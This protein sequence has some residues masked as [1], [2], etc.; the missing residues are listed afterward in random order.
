MKKN[1]FASFHTR[2]LMAAVLAVLCTFTTS[3]DN[4]EEDAPAQ[5]KTVADIVVES[6]DFTILEAAMR[7]AGQLDAFK[8][9]NLTV[10]APNDAAFRA[11][12]VTDATSL[13]ALSKEQLT[14][15]LQYHVLKAAV[16]S[17]GFPMEKNKPVQTSLSIN[18]QAVVA[19][20]TNGSGGLFINGAKVITPDVQAANGVI[21]VID[22]I[23][24]P[25]PTGSGGSLVGVVQ[26]D[27]SL[28]LLGVAALRIAT[29]NPA[30]AAVLTGTQPY[31]TFAPTNSA[32]RAL[33]L[34]TADTI[35]KVP[36]AKLTAILANHVVSGRL[37]SNDLTTGDVTAYSTGKLT[38]NSGSTVTVK[39]S[40]IASPATVTRA[41]MTATNGVVH[42]IDKVLL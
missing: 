25:P 5:P 13:T 27:T 10:F 2:T 23:L 29:L 15:I 31:T 34:G 8:N 38:V 11:S 39:S 36:V 42:K 20:V 30:L 33:K 12:G 28:S 40:G 21:H 37:F 9:P 32:F 3:C 22:H 17:S 18:N 26:A 7:Q 41:N 14:G 6:S 35:N 24:L 4:S 16:A 1:L 19:Y